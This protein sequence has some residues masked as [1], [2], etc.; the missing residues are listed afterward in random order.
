MRQ[1]E[2]KIKIDIK[3]NK[4]WEF[5]V[6]LSGS[7]KGWV[8]GTCESNNQNCFYVYTVHIG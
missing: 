6:D 7:D 4:L 3:K 5:G 2:C 8:A 1:A